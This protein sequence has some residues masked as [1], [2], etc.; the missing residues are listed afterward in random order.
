[1]LC[2]RAM[3]VCYVG[4]LPHVIIVAAHVHC[5]N[6]LLSKEIAPYFI[7]YYVSLLCLNVFVVVDNVFGI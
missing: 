4:V 2:G 5:S 1:M 7:H 3:W 6:H